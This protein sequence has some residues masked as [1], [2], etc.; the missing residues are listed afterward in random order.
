MGEIQDTSAQNNSGELF[1]SR[2][3]LR[4]GK[5]FGTLPN[6]KSALRSLYETS[7]GIYLQ[8]I[9]RRDTRYPLGY[10][11]VGYELGRSW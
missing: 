9:P 10:M 5:N 2:I 1:L 3:V 8:E 11:G 4:L 7:A 6:G